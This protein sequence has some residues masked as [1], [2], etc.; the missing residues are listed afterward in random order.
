[1]EELR[2]LVQEE[3]KK[4]HLTI[5]GLSEVMK[6]SYTVYSQYTTYGYMTA[7]NYDHFRE[8]FPEWRDVEIET[9]YLPKKAI[10]RPRKLTRKQEAIDLAYRMLN[11]YEKTVLPN[12][13][14]GHEKEII[15]ELGNRGIQ[16]E[17]IET[18]HI[19]DNKVEYGYSLR[20]INEPR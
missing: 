9:R 13:F 11:T 12:Y 4:R 3:A 16:A 10:V 7:A 17:V 8:L 1:M 2:L 20:R 18:K 19:Y 15:K 6:F 5:K 14:L